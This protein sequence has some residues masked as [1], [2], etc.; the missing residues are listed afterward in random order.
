MAP[1][2]ENFGEFY[3]IHLPAKSL[4]EGVQ[5]AQPGQAVFEMTDEPE[6]FISK[7]PFNRSEM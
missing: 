3:H 2:S 5:S 4:G 1:E 7:R 6:P